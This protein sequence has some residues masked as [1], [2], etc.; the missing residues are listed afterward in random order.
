MSEVRPCSWWFPGQACAGVIK[1]GTPLPQSTLDVL[2]RAGRAPRQDAVRGVR[3]RSAQGAD[4]AAR[5]V[6]FLLQSLPTNQHTAKPRYQHT[7]GKHTK[8]PVN[9][10]NL[11][12][13][14]T[15]SS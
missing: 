9:I 7:Y 1:D 11:Q 8:I 4:Q 12:Q 10:L 14:L 13:V 15:S 5:L 2:I 3:G 6:I